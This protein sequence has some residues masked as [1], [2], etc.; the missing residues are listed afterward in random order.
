MTEEY[1]TREK[2]FSVKFDFMKTLKI[3]TKEEYQEVKKYYAKGLI[4]L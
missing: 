1:I 4:S 3:V 2:E